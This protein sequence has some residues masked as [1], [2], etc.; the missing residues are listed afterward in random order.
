MRRGFIVAVDGAQLVNVCLCRQ[1]RGAKNAVTPVLFDVELAEQL[2]RINWW[3]AASIRRN[4]TNLTPGVALSLR[5]R[6]LHG[7]G[8]VAVVLDALKVIET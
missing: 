5:G 4:L 7:C 6:G 1:P 2:V 3:L 8:G